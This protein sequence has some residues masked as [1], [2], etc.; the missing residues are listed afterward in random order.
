[1]SNELAQRDEQIALLK[2]REDNY[3]Q[4]LLEKE[5]MYKQDTMVRGDDDNQEVVD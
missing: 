5:N 4:M 3:E 2:K 1:M